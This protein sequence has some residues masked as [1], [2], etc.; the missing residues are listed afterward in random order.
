MHVMIYEIP[1]EICGMTLV[2]LFIIYS[3]I[4]DNKFVCLEFILIVELNGSAVE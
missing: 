1:Y 3:I 2:W 4:L